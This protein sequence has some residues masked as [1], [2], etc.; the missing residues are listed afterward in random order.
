MRQ[1]TPEQAR[2]VLQI[3][4]EECRYK[5][6][7]HDADAFVYHVTRADHPCMEYRFMGGLGFGGK[8]RNNGNRG[9][10]P[11]VDCYG[12]DETSERLE[13]MLKTNLRLK[14]LFK[15]HS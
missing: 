8:F 7:E 2:S 13:M 4:R 15:T 6:E 14:A 1:I 5:C 12:E 3:L 10:A 9:N 11:Y